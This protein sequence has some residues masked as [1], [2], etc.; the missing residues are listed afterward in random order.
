MKIAIIGAGLA[1]LTLAKKLSTEFEVTLFEKARGP[2]GRMSTRRAAPFAFDHGAQY[3][4]ASDPRFEAFLTDLQSEGLVALW[5]EQIAL[6]GG[7]EVS[8][9]LKYVGAPAMNAICKHLAGEIALQTAV[10]VTGLVA[11][12]DGWHLE[13]AAGAGWGP[14]DW[15]IS[16]APSVQTAA[17]MPDHFAGQA[18]L[19]DVEMRG[20]FTLMLGFETV[21]DMPWQAM[22]SAASPVGWMAVNSAKPGRPEANAVVLQSSNA[23]AETHLE[24]P[25][26][27]VT[28]MLLAAGSALA[29]RDLS[30]ASHQTLHRWRYAATPRPAGL[31]FLIDDAQRLAACGDWCLGSKVEAA[32]LS[33]YALADRLLATAKT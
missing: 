19:A 6:H 17:L 14:F 18:A 15:V 11:Q 4:T 13:E 12:P 20:C 30:A 24:A 1:G 8:D 7:A 31:P 33:A 10:Q 28:Q 23:W 27:Q 26:E 21:F 9:K 32:F 5:P 25:T 2:G 16:T 3:F 29:G 22:K